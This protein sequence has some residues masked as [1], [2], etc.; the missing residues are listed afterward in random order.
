MY[1]WLNLY[2]IIFKFP[3]IK[4]LMSKTVSEETNDAVFIDR[5]KLKQVSLHNL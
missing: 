2:T 5:L 3:S 4:G 1:I